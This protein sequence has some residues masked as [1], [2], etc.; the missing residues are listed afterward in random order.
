M[1]LLLA[2]LAVGLPNLAVA[3]PLPATLS[4]PGKP[5]FEAKSPE[6][7]AITLKRLSSQPFLEVLQRLA[8]ERGFGQAVN[9]RFRGEKVSDRRVRIIIEGVEADK[10]RLLEQALTDMVTGKTPENDRQRLIIVYQEMKRRHE[11][12]E[13]IG[14]RLPPNFLE[15][16][17][18][19][20]E[21]YQNEI[22]PPILRKLR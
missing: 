6:E 19:R 9:G 17:R 12:L 4:P 1:R 3:A 5:L 11:R 7:A 10:L 8:N 21:S 15:Q 14:G 2:L 20:L 22:N 13:Q 18:T 16:E